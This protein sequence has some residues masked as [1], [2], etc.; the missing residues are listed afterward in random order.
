MIN[1]THFISVLPMSGDTYYTS[2]LKQL[3]PEWVRIYI[4][5]LEAVAV[6]LIKLK[7]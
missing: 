5:E 3:T 1:P 6:F 7:Y 2:P 4:T